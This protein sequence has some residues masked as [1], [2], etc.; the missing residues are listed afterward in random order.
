MVVFDFA[1]RAEGDGRLSRVPSAPKITDIT[2]SINV[3]DGAEHVPRV[4]VEFHKAKV[5]LLLD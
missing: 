4:H 2:K 5:V 1:R 3:F